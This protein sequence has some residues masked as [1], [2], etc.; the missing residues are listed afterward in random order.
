MRGC[1]FQELTIFSHAQSHHGPEDLPDF[2][3]G[4]VATKATQVEDS[5]A[6][7]GHRFDNGAMISAQNGLGSEEII[8][9][10]TRGYVIRGTTFMSGTRHSDTHVQYE[11]NTAT[12]IGPFEPWNTPFPLVKEAADLIV[13]GGLKAEALARCPSRAVVKADFQCFSEWSICSHRLAAL[14]A[15]R[16]GIAI[17]R[18]GDL[19]H[20]LIEEGKGVAAASGVELHEDPV[21]DEQDRRHDQSSAFDAL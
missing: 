12:W 8:A 3:L 17:L 1:A 18:L 14:A 19:L 7:A 21:G 2:E 6:T 10:H 16:R 20:D 11:L 5:I 13:A 15:F 4:I 9:A